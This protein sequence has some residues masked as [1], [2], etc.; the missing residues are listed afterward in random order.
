MACVTVKVKVSYLINMCAYLPSLGL[1]DGYI[2]Q[3]V[4]CGHWNARTMVT[5]L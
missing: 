5:F 3:S 4:L 2:T 1:V